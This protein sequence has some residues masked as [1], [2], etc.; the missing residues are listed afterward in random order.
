MQ[1]FL[2]KSFEKQF[3]KLPKKIKQR[4]IE[5]LSAFVSDPMDY[6]LHN[7]ALMGEWMG[8]RNIDISGDIRAIYKRVDEKVV[9]FVAVGSHSTLYE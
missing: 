7:H 3:K 1:Y 8:H 9:R 6:R 5:R 4:V 2:S